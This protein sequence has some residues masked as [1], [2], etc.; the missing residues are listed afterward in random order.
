LIAGFF[1]WAFLPNFSCT[2]PSLDPSAPP[3]TK[4]N[5]QGWRYVWYASGSLVFIMSILRIT[6]VRAPDIRIACETY[7]DVNVDTPKRDPQVPCR[8][9]QRC[10]VCRNTAVHSQQVQPPLQSY[11]REDGSLW[12][13]R[14]PHRSRKQKQVG[15]RRSRPPSPWSILHQTHWY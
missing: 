13:R 14:P 15:F 6:V 3:C 4:S 2:D 10:R 1:A 7:T 5:N 12:Y 9:R 11:A 8:R